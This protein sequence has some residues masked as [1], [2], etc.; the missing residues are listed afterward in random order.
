MLDNL[1]SVLDEGEQAGR[2][3]PGFEGYEHVVSR[4]AQGAHQS[5]LLLT[6]REQAGPVRLL[7]S[8]YAFMRTLRLGG[9]DVRAGERLLC[10]KEVQ[11]TQQEKAH[12]IEQYAG[13]PLALRMVSESIAERFAGQIDQFLAAGPVIFGSMSA[14][15][16]EHWVRLSRLEQ[17]L[18]RWLAIVREPVTLEELRAVM[19]EFRAQG[20]V[21]ALDRLS[22]RSLIERGQRAGSFTL[23]SVVLEYV[24]AVLIAAVPE[25]IEQGQVDLLIQHGLELAQSRED[26]RLAQERLLLRPILARLQSMS[27]RQDEVDALLLMQLDQ[28][29]EREDSAQG[30]GP[31]N[32]VALV[33]LLRGH[34]R[35][36]DLSQL[37]LRGA[38]LQGVQMQDA[39]LCGATLH[40]TLLTEAMPAIWSV[41]TSPSDQYWAAGS[42]RGEVRVWC[43]GGQRLHQVWQAHTDN[44]FT[45]TFSPDERTLAT[46]SWDGSVKLWDLHS[47]ALLWTAWH[48]GPIQSLVFSPDGRTLASGGVDACVRFW[49]VSSGKQRQT[50]VSPGDTVNVLA[51]AWSPDGQRLAAGCSDGSIRLWQMGLTGQEQRAKPGRCLVIVS[52]SMVWPLPRMGPDWPVGVGMGA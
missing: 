50:L 32:L 48:A 43:E 37:T 1:E 23:Q 3:R 51:L 18:L 38:N 5:C 7:E 12:L 21:N 49:E 41:A 31:A 44:L 24:T 27:Q 14:L 40:G 35:G 20:V 10:E 47:G 4:M 34:L 22:R 13:N 30:Y 19:V 46:G 33:R 39:N 29:R 17:T 11:G 2:F 25:E 15:L 36:L 45:L 16:D 42:W 28:L 26:I 6:S 52:G 9:L 8:R